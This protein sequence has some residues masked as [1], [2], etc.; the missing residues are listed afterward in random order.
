MDVLTF[1]RCSLPLLTSLERD[2]A[3]THL[4]KY[5]PDNLRQSV[6]RMCALSLAVC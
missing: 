6:T 1:S 2:S 4:L 5:H 3:E